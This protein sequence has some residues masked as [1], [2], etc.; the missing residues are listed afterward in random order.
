MS[1]PIRI[2]RNVPYASAIG[3]ILGSYGYDVGWMEPAGSPPPNGTPPALALIS[4]D[5][6]GAQALE[7]VETLRAN[8]FQNKI[9]VVGT[10]I[11]ETGI[12]E[13]LAKRGADFISA[14]SGPGDVVSRIRQL[15]P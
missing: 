7:Q 5:L 3:E 12:R 6:S 4:L 10:T 15:L 11:P 14:L 2:D 9:A 1:R 8:G 13:N